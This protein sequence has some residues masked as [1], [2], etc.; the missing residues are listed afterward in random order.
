MGLY[1]RF[2]YPRE[3]KENGEIAPVAGTDFFL[4]QNP[5]EFEDFVAEVFERYFGGIAT[6]TSRSGDFG[7]DIEHQREDGLYLGQAK[8]YKVD[9]DFSPIAK[10]HSNMVKR[11]AKGGFV[12]TT[13]SFTFNARQ[14]AEGLNIDLIDG[15]KLVEYWLSGFERTDKDLIMQ[16]S[17][18]LT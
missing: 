6:T 10:I 3:K 15:V 2:N 1:F 13:S 12:V 16:I 18:K 4:K 14:Y 5:Y 7:V 11:G 9:L 8:A 17:P